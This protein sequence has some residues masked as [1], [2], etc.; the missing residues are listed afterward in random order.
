MKGGV[1]DEG[2]FKEGFCFKLSFVLDGKKQFIVCA[3]ELNVKEEWME[4]I[5]QTKTI[6]DN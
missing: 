3:D 1:E 2:N 6:Y 4:A 5:I